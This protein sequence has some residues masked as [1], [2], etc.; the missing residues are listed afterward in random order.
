MYMIKNNKKIVGVIL[1]ASLYKSISSKPLKPYTGDIIH[2]PYILRNM[3]SLQQFVF[4]FTKDTVNEWRFF[5]DQ[6]MGGI[7][8]GK[9]SLNKDGDKF[10]VKI[11]GDVR[12]DNNGGFIQLRTS[13][14]LFNKSLMFKLLHNSENRG[15]K[16]KGIRLNVKGN[17]DI[18]HIFIMNTDEIT[19]IG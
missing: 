5:S 9:V 11:E 2:N 17:E 7:S 10:F 15:K 3:S 16:L 14:S 6:V 12:T 8:E 13:T 1:I 18:Y 19:K 4:P